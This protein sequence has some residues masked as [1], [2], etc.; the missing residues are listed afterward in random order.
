MPRPKIVLATPSA[1]TWKAKMGACTVEMAATAASAGIEIEMI[2]AEGAY[3]ETNRNRIV[4]RVLAMAEPP[5]GIMW[6]DSDMQFPRHSLLGLL[7]RQKDIIGATYRERQA[8]HRY[9][10]CFVDDDDAR[11]LEGGVQPMSRMPGGMILVRT[12]VYR[13]LSPPWYRL[14]EDGWRD[15]YAFC[16]AAIAAGYEVWCDMDLTKHVIHRGEQ[17]VGWF[18]EEEIPIRR[19]A[20]DRVRKIPPR[21]GSAEPG[22]GFALSALENV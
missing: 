1:G 16:V 19:G 3:T 2:G 21:T 10:G 22:G 8:P 7:S 14:D 13:R 15:D 4:Q 5:A 12:E 11:A 18:E 17:E 6:V 20:E 9:L